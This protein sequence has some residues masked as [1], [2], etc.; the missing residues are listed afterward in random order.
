M[1][2][3]AKFEPALQ[4]NA[5]GHTAH[6][7]GRHDACLARRYIPESTHEELLDSK[8]RRDHQDYCDL[9]TLHPGF[10]DVE[11][12]CMNHAEPGKECD[13]FKNRVLKR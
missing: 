11:A 9:I 1:M 8:R 7:L 3:W 10:S 13:F 4:P 6:L 2:L 5:D 12:Y